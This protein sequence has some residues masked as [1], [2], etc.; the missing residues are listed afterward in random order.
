[1]KKCI[2][3][4]FLM[5]AIFSILAC[6]GLRFSQL[7]PAAK[8]YHPKRIAVF[9]ADVG[10]YEEARNS[11]DQIVPGV[12]MDKKW[13]T[14]IADTASLNRQIASNEELRK[15]MTDYISKFQTLN[16]SDPAL[17]KKIGELTQTDAFLMVAVDY[18]N[19]TV[20]KDKK[21]AKVS[22]GLKLIDAETGKIMWKAGHHLAESY[23]LLK[24]DLSD[25]AR[26]V[27]KDMVSEMP[28]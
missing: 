5:I 16:Y 27:V 22:I 19:Y 26:S 18:W 10:T 13:F 4:F 14:D 2:V 8:D 17:T 3:V 15:S 21:L 1:M 20:E 28:H 9:P 24:P 12:L 25:V 11:I 6:G 23:M 7:D